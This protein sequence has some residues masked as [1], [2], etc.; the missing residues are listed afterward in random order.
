MDEELD[1][2]DVPLI[3]E[4]LHRVQAVSLILGR[5]LR[6]PKAS[7]DS[8]KQQYTDPSLRLI[9]VIDE[10]V[11]QDEPKPTWGFIVKALKSPLIRELRLAKKIEA[12]YCCLPTKSIGM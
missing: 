2:D 4:K 1:D 8:I 6:I 12:N 11:K 9:S 10:F 7:L 5:L 3:V